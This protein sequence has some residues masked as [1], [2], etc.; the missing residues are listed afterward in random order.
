MTQE[1]E[2]IYNE[3]RLDYYF[4]AEEYSNPYTGIEA[5]YWSDGWE[6]AAEDAE[7]EQVGRGERDGPYQ[8]PDGVTN[9]N[10]EL[11]QAEACIAT[12]RA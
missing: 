10:R 5:E 8:S 3:G 12:R 7:A 6:D 11:D 2:D 9:L 1:Q 4:G